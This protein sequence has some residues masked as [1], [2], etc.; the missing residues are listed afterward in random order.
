MNLFGKLFLFAIFSLLLNVPAG[1]DE[2]QRLKYNHP[3]LVVDLGVGLWAWPLPMDFNGDGHKDIVMCCADRPYNGVYLFEHPGTPGKMPVFKKAKRISKGVWNPQ[4]TFVNGQPQVITPGCR[5]PDFGTTGLDHPVEIPLPA[6]PD[7]ERFTEE[8]LSR[9]L[10]WKYVDY[11]GDGNL[12][13]MC[14]YIRTYLYIARNSGTNE[15]PV[16]EKPVLIKEVTRKDGHDFNGIRCPD[17]VDFD[18]DGDLDI[19]A[20][21]SL[22]GFVYLENIG[23]RANPK[24]QDGAKLC[25]EDGSLLVM[26]I[27]MITPVACDW[28]DDGDWDI[29]CGDEDGRVAFIEN[30][31]KWKD[32]LPV[33]LTPRYFQQ[34]A[35]ELK[36]G[37][38]STPCGYD[39]DGDGDWDILSGNTAGHLVFFENLS[40]PNVDSPKWAAPKFLETD[41]K[42]FRIMAG[43]YGSV[44]GPG[45]AKWGYT[46][47]TVGDWDNDG[48]PDIVANSVWGK[49]FW[50]KNIGTRSKP[51]LSAPE[52]IEVEWDGSQPDLGFGNLRP[53]GKALLTHWRTTPCVYDWN[54]DGLLDL[55]MLDH[56]GY[57]AFFERKKEGQQLL[58]LPPKRTLL[59][60]D[61]NPVRLNDKVAGRSG[62]YK[63]CI[64]DYDCDG[65]ADFLYNNSDNAEF[66]KQ[67][68]QQGVTRIFQ[69]MGLIDSRNI[70]G[71]EPAIST[72]DFNGD[73]IPDPIMGGEDGFFYHKQNDIA[74]KSR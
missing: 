63:I 42:I 20:A 53:E 15:A 49:V 46:V 47:L 57:L 21:D 60:R 66:C 67:M 23:D 2:L 25:L 71:H 40:G 22:D 1:A 5:Y 14:C 32:G 37:A 38:L 16:Y 44:Q 52:P 24:Y 48:L 18:G 7:S 74:P 55:L 30:T 3:G 59:Y 51:K 9:E 29:I 27:E 39:W 11:D 17:M 43:L 19:I 34:E 68:E 36:C 62:R 26:D 56:E 10:T 8:S 12:D 70:Y 65:N 61:G 28:D 73:G 45:E 4:I 41:G 72:V 58:L 69:R 6:N 50:L 33:F 35:D 31:G 13:I 54:K 64:V